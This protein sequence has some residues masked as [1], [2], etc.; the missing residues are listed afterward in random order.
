VLAVSA[1]RIALGSAS[2]GSGTDAWTAELMSLPLGQALV[3]LVGVGIGAFAGFSVYTGLSDRWKE[4][5]LPSGHT[6]TIGTVVSVLARVGFV[7]RGAAFAVV[8]VLF[9]WAA[10]THDP[11][12]SG[13]LDQAL[14]RLAH[15]PLGP[16]LLAAV[17][18]GL[19]CFG[20]FCFVWARHLDR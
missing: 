4:K 2:S 16:F 6:G 8:G 13:G 10:V 18:V 3:A 7:G 15:Q 11:D 12:K 9:V 17:A 5:I 1:V 19:A 20:G 14:S